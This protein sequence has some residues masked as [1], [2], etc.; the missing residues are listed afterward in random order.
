MRLEQMS[1]DQELDN[2]LREW[3]IEATLPP[4][5]RDRVWQRV[6]RE[7]DRVAGTMAS[8][9][10]EGFWGTWSRWIGQGLARPSLAVSY[11]TLLLLAGLVAGYWQARSTEARAL[12]SLSSRYVQM[13]DP[14]RIPVQPK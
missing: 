6:D 11:V 9:Q 10:A 14:Y 7:R 2:T 13:L 5:F 3:K 12:E 8:P 1:S 4:R